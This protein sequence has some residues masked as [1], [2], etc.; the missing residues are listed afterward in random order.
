MF[1]KGGHYNMPH[2]KYERFDHQDGIRGVRISETQKQG[3]INFI[4]SW[5]QLTMYDFQLGMSANVYVYNCS[6]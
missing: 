4:P 1:T 2:Y 6:D 5:K 3:M